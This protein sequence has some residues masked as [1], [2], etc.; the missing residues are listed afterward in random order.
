LIILGGVGGWLK[1]AEFQRKILPYNLFFRYQVFDL[2]IP[3]NW[4]GKLVWL[5][6]SLTKGFVLCQQLP[7]AIPRF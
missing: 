3:L 5:P 1:V 7:P 6:H 2:I 4:Q